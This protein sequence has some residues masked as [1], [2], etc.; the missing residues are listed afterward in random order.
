MQVSK[1]STKIFVDTRWY[2]WGGEDD[3]KGWKPSPR[4]VCFELEP[5]EKCLPKLARMIDLSLRSSLFE[6]HLVRLAI[7]IVVKAHILEIVK[8]ECEGCKTKWSTSEDHKM[9]PRC[10]G[11]WKDNVNVVLSKALF[12]IDIKTISDICRKMMEMRNR[13]E[14]NLQMINDAKIK[15]ESALKTVNNGKH[16]V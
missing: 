6:K 12:E 14:K 8:K 10:K 5:Y 13:P 11:P 3:D 1:N 4:G 2:Y 15:N 7:A 16:L 9:V